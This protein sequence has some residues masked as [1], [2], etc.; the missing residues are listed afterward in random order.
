M[1]KDRKNRSLMF[2]S[3]DEYQCFLQKIRD[4]KDMEISKLYNKTAEQVLELSGQ[5]D[6]VPV[7]LKKILRKFNISAVPKD[8][9]ELDTQLNEKFSNVHILGVYVSNEKDAAIFYNK[10]D[11]ED[12]HRYRFTIAHELAHCCLQGEKSHIEFRVDG[13]ELDENE[14]AAN[15]FAGA[16][17]IPEKSLNKV[18]DELIVPSLHALADIFEVS[19]NVMKAR[20]KYLNIQESILGFNY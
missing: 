16:L 14:L 20:L 7:D 13:L 17:L 8:F 4:K 15:T 5:A 2:S 11:V 6:A 19:E 12:G 3:K 1:I 18:L 10:A 9:S